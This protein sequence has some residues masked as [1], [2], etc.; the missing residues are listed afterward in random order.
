MTHF[1]AF[2]RTLCFILNGDDVLLLK[3]A[4]TKRLYAN[5]YNGVGGH[6]ERDED[7]LSSLHREVLEETGLTIV[8]PRLGAVIVADEGQ[9][10]GVVIFVY[11]AI[12]LGRDVRASPEG[13]LQWVRRDRLMD[14]ALVPDLRELLPRLLNAPAGR[15]LYGHY[16]ADGLQFR[17]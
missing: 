6:V 5:L 8:S 14:Y 4:A 1:T 17:L 16:G 13:D 10:H 9:A 15:V 12:A 3:G 2:P 11:T 7:V